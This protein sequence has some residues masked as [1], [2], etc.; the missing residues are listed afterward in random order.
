MS[1]D[2]SRRAFLRSAAIAAV[3]AA[4]GL[5]GCGTSRAAASSSSSAASSIPS[6]PSDAK[7]SAQSGDAAANKGGTKPLVVY[8]SY[9][10]N[11]DTMAHWI[12]N[13]SG[14]DLSRVTVKDTYPDDY[15]ATV[16]RAKKELDSGARPQITVDLDAN[17]LAGYST[18]FFGFPIWWYDLPTPM[19]TLLESYDLSGKEVVPFFSHGGS[20]SGANSLPTLESLAKGATVR[21]SDALSIPGDNVANSEQEVR[22]WVKKLGYSVS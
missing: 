2:I 19:C 4:V 9:T 3:G 5:A 13:E 22:A 20:A 12:A 14:G 17:K 1:S 8:F 11:T 7:Q 21:S 15:D 10:G 16:D 18:V 6:S